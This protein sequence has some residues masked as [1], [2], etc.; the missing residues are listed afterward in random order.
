M[1]VGRNRSLSAHARNLLAILAAAGSRWNHGYDLCRQAGIKSG[2]LYPLLIRLEEQ[3]YLEA[4]WQAPAE[5]GRPPRHAY[6]LT[7][8]GL[9]LAR[10]NP[11]PA[12]TARPASGPRETF[13]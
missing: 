11:P 4:E 8:A 12:A 10:D 9:Q 2:T 3:G 13:A 1:P 6:R 5:R 7:A